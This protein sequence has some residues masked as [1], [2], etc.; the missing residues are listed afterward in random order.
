MNLDPK[1]MHPLRRDLRRV[2]RL[3]R[4]LRIV[5]VVM[6]LLAASNAVSAQAPPQVRF[7]GCSHAIPGDLRGFRTFFE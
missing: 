5:S 3:T 7:N 2:A 4:R 1:Y 6:V